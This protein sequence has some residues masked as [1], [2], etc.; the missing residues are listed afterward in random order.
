MRRETER[1]ETTTRVLFCGSDTRGAG[2]KLLANYYVIFSIPGTCLPATGSRISDVF[3]RILLVGGH[4]TQ[5]SASSSTL[6]CRVWHLIESN[7][8]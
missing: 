2:R 8:D 3:K 4:V 7:D 5:Q 1:L 6:V